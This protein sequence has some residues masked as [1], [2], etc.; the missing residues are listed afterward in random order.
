[1]SVRLFADNQFAYSNLFSS[2]GSVAPN[3]LSGLSA[4]WDSF[5]A[6][7]ALP[8]VFTAL[9]PAVLPRPPMY[10]TTLA[11]AVDS[12]GN[13]MQSASAY[14]SPQF[15][16][17]SSFLALSNAFQLAGA[18]TAQQTGVFRS[19]LQVGIDTVSYQPMPERILED[20]F[21]GGLGA[22]N[23]PKLSNLA[24]SPEAVLALSQ[25]NKE[26]GTK[27]LKDV[28]EQLKNEYGIECEYIESMTKEQAQALGIPAE[29]IDKA[30]G[31]KAIKFA[32]GDMMMDANGNGAIDI[33]DYKFD[34]AVKKIEDNIKQAYGLN[35]EQVGEL[36][37]Q[38]TT[39][40]GKKALGSLSGDLEFQIA[41]T[42]RQVT[43]TLVHTSYRAQQEY[44]AQQQ[45]NPFSLGAYGGPVE[46][47]QWYH[48]NPQMGVNR[49][50]MNPLGTMG[51]MPTAL[52]L[53]AQAMTF[54]V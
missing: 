32:N 14:G 11:T 52:S 29:H 21:S 31:K 48:W 39:P 15:P 41:A 19:G 43:P 46:T 4:S 1:M 36:M 13:F 37:K 42:Q 38:Y 53:F 25:I 16:G 17:Y 54:A 45:Y 34:D 20:E 12:F 7:V 51:N 27:T 8:Q 10:N 30:I 50:A 47:P 44:G 6:Q 26:G 9:P 18:Y 49:A 28:A 5:A 23:G 3:R 40:E 22:G 24:N 2:L 35:D 33:S